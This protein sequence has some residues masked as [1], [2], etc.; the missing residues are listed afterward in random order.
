MS[1]APVDAPNPPTPEDADDEEMPRVVMTR[2]RTVIAFVLFVASPV[3][4]LYFV[5]PQLAG[6]DNAWDSGTATRSGS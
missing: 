2:E 1:S 4:F 3:G 6:L 5:L